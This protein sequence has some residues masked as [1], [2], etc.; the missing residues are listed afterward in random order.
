MIPEPDESTPEPP[1]PTL[2]EI[3]NGGA[4]G[5]MQFQAVKATVEQQIDAAF[6]MFR[7]L[8]AGAVGGLSTSTEQ[9]LYLK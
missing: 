8:G 9:F 4:G 7:V 1:Q 5:D 6:G 2:L 3:L